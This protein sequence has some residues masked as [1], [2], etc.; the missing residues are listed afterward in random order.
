VL[1]LIDIDEDHQDLVRWLFL[2][3]PLM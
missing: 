1:A 3:Y 2:W